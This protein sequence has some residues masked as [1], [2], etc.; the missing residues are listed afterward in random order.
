MRARSA[1]EIFSGPPMLTTPLRRVR[2]RHAGHLGGDVVGGD[3][4][5]QRIGCS[6]FI[7]H[8]E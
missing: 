5:N 3:R 1:N 7:A 4:L 2:R 6:H 8:V